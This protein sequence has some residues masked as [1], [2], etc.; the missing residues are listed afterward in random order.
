MIHMNAYPERMI[1][2][3]H[4]AELGSDSLRQENRDSRSNSQKFN[5]RN[6]PQAAQDSLQ[7]VVTKEKRVTTA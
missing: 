6:A 4:R 1:F 7:L 5:V 3:K 2:L